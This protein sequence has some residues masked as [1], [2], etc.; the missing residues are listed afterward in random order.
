VSV[1]G[2]VVGQIGSGLLILLGV[3][4][5]DKQDDLDWMFEKVP[6]LR[7][8]EDDQGKMNRSLIE[9]GGELLVVSQF[10]L[11]GDTRKGRRPSF[12][13]AMAPESATRIIDQLV[14]RWRASG[15]RVETGV[16]GAMMDVS[17]VNAGPVTILLD[18]PSS[19]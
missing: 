15:L 13:D 9:V 1:D 8:F 2:R 4:Q 19:R 10:T 3:H 5:A 11:L 17:L 7:I 6:S 14:V 12:C 18:S 16:F